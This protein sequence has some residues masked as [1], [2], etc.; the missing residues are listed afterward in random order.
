[1][2]AL[3]A[4]AALALAACGTHADN[5]CED[6][7]L[8]RSQSDDQIA[9]CQAEAK[10]LTIEARASGCGSAFDLYFSCADDH[11]V[12]TGNVPGFPG[13]SGPR[14]A[15]DSCLTAARKNN[16]CGVLDV[17]LSACPSSTPAPDPV[18]APCG[19]TEL[20]SSRCFLDD[21]ADV[22]RPQPIELV[23]FSHCV[24]QCP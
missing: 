24:Q 16:S 17:R 13:C 11:Y 4:A 18:P 20:C 15:L 2:R 6:I 21:V 3:L 7:G 23:N 22:C 8:C 10:V 1:M 5:V 12:C 14:A 19:A 9:A